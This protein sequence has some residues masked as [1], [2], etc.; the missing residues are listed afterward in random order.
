MAAQKNTTFVQLHH[1]FQIPYAIQLI[2]KCVFQISQHNNLVEDGL[3]EYII[4]FVKRPVRFNP[5]IL[6]SFSEIFQDVPGST[7]R[8]KKI[9]Q[10]NKDKK[11]ISRPNSENPAYINKN[12]KS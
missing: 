1:L 12:L 5:A 6:M 4:V 8:E 2:R 3:P 9:V 11:K 10:G 7:M